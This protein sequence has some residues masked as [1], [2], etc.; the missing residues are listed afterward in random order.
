MNTISQTV[1]IVD[2]DPSIADSLLR[3]LEFENLEAQAFSSEEDFMGI[4][5]QTL[6]GCI[7]LDINMPQMSGI[8]LQR[9]LVD[10][11]IDLPIIFLTGSGDIPLSSQAFRTGALDFIEKP[12]DIDKLLERIHEALARE[13]GQWHGR[14]RRDL[15]RQRYARLTPREKEILKWVSAGYSSKDI[16]RVVGISSRTIDVHRAHMA[17]KLEVDSLAELVLIALE[18][19]ADA[20]LGA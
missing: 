3:L 9:W 17:V 18:L 10:N 1:Y 4:C 2:D 7:L 6:R 14:V 19:D 13:A 20:D 15:L 16:A 5:G 11:G 8:E 12:F